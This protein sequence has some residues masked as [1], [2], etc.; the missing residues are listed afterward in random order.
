[1]DQPTSGAGGRHRRTR[2]YGRSI[3]G[4]SP[5]DA[6]ARDIMDARRIYMEDGLYTPEIRQSLLEVIRL[7]KELYPEIFTR[8]LHG[9]R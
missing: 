6:L 8:G 1:M 2:T 5:R 9:N 3:P 4:E 7:N